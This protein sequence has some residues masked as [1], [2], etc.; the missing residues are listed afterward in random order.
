LKG[1]HLAKLIN[2]PTGKQ[3]SADLAAAI[4]KAQTELEAA[5]AA[6]VVAEE[7][8]EANLLTADKATLRGFLD[9]KTEASI[10]VDQAR[11]RILRLERDHEAALETEAAESRRRRYDEAKA[12]SEAAR[13]KLADEY[14][15]L[16]Q[17]LRTLLKVVSE[18][19]AAVD[20]VNEDPPDGAVRLEKAEDF[21]SA[22]TLYREEVGRSVV[23]VWVACGDRTI[24]IPDDMQRRVRSEAKPRRDGILYGSVQ[25]ESGGFLEVEQRR[26]TRVEFLPHE[27]GRRVGSLASTLELPALFAGASPFWEADNYAPYQVI[28]RLEKP[29]VPPPVRAER[30]PEVEWRNPPKEDVP[31]AE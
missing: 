4:T 21:R 25:T 27:D 20:A 29:M 3:S 10:D 1:N 12:A 11:A 17:G 13:K 15:K 5:E 22:R 6:V 26:F 28:Q 18:A 23:D 14:P 30:K 7:Q 9:A 24:P 19:D 8:Y 31:N 2:K 16:A